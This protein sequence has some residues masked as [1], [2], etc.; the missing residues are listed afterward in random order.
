MDRRTIIALVLTVIILFVFQTYFA[1]KPQ[2]TGEQTQSK[3]QAKPKE[4]VKPQ[5]Q[6]AGKEEIQ[7][8]EIGPKGVAAPLKPRIETKPPKD[9]VVETPFLK[10]TLTDFGGGIKSVLLKKYKETVKG[11]KDKEMIED[12]KPYTY[13]PT[14][15]QT[16]NNQMF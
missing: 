5:G 7:S 11:D 12:V 6:V 10:V 2:Q 3:E 16:I 13:L 4:E 15:T 8:K 14:I 1:P 9:V